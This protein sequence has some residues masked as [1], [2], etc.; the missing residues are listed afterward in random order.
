MRAL[1]RS[2][3]IACL[4]PAIAIAW[5]CWVCPAWA[6]GGGGADATTLQGALDD[7]CTLVFGIPLT[8]C[9][10]FPSSPTDLPTPIVV[11]VSALG[12]IPPDSVRI[13]DGICE[14]AVALSPQ[15]LCPDIA[16]N[17]VNSPPLFPIV[18][19]DEEEPFAKSRIALSYLTPLAL[20]PGAVPTQSSDPRAT[21]FFYAEVLEGTDGEHT[22]HLLY[23]YTPRTTKHL[24]R[25]Q[26]ANFSL[27]LVVY[28]QSG[29]TERTVPATVQ[30]VAACNHADCLT[31]NVSGSFSGNG[32]QTVSAAQLGIQFRYDF[33]PSP[34]SAT[35]HAIF[36]LRVPLLVNRKNDSPYFGTSTPTCPNGANLNSGYCLAFSQEELGH[37]AGFL[38]VG[39]YVGM[40]PSASPYPHGGS[41]STIAPPALPFT[42]S[43][44]GDPLAVSAFVAISTDGK[45]VISKRLF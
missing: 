6:G 9:Q 11:E 19:F 32:T 15:P 26:V 17:A 25:G 3:R 42:A 23:D 35:P 30:L 10:R 33:G 45:V 12:N 14:P 18:S 4:T 20:E 28:D 41:P 29:G 39:R 21:S 38:G 8:S 7:L 36:E 44:F 40:A 5:L 22:L 16:V 24:A 43:F 37:A 2:A 31:A 34:N 1:A 13:D 27:P